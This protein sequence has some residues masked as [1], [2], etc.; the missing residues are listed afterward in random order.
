AIE[1]WIIMVTNIHEEATEEDVTDF[2]SDFGDVKGLHLNLD[3]QTGYVKGYCLVEYDTS[4][5]AEKAI[6][7]ARG[8]ELLGKTL[9]ADFCF[10]QTPHVSTQRGRRERS[11]SP[12]RK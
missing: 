7:G 6:M 2:F 11:R 4:T 9:D 5:E 10:V 3:R 1:G 8:T 12:L